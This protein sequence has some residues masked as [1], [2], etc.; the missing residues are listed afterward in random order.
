MTGIKPSDLILLDCEVGLSGGG[1]AALLTVATIEEIE[2]RESRIITLL[3]RTDEAATMSRFLAE[4]AEAAGM[5]APPTDQR[6]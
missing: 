4:A 3:M 2:R 6:Q 1:V 5:G